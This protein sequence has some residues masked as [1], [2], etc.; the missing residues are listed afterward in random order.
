MKLSNSK[1]AVVQLVLLALLGSAS[2]G[3][4]QTTTTNIRGTV[5]VSDEGGTLPGV[6]VVAVNQDTGFEHNAS[7]REDGS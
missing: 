2:P 5:T 7:T 4:A 6:R 1:L 3:A